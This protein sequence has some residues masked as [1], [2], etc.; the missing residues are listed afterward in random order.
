[1]WYPLTYTMIGAPT[2]A[3]CSGEARNMM[4]GNLLRDY[5]ERLPQAE[6]VAR[7]LMT[8][9]WLEDAGYPDDA[10]RLRGSIWYLLVQDGGYILARY[11][12]LSTAILRA[13]VHWGPA[14]CARYMDTPISRRQ[15]YAC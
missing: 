15:R 7:E 6:R 1:M 13:A 8:S 3:I 9:D 14:R 4:L 12:E 11:G 5:Q 2:P 10:A